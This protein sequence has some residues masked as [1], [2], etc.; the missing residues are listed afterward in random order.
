MKYYSEEEIL[1]TFPYWSNLTKDVTKE[2][3]DHMTGIETFAETDQRSSDRERIRMELWKEMYI[4]S[5]LSGS[6]PDHAEVIG[7]NAVDR[8]DKQ[9]PNS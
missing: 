1:M 5:R 7:R 6:L 8:F 2:I 9:F 3:V 4:Q